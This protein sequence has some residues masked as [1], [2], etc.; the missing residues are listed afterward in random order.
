MGLVN[1]K[2]WM[3]IQ[4]RTFKILSFRLIK[5]VYF[6]VEPY[7]LWKVKVIKLV[8]KVHAEECTIQNK[9]DQEVSRFIPTW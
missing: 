6:L 7:K 3:F 1:L 8:Y 5:L 4:V 9:K 2:A